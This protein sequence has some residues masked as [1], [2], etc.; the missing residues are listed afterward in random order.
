M[1]RGDIVLDS[2]ICISR[3]LGILSSKGGCLHKRR[4][5]NRDVFI[6]DVTNTRRGSGL[7][8]PGHVCFR[9]YY[10]T[11]IRQRL[12]VLVVLIVSWYHS[13]NSRPLS[14]YS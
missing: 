1:S 4:K 13:I 12:H 3:L 9:S 2:R 8:I 10:P 6:G 14:G 7:A 11:T 5:T